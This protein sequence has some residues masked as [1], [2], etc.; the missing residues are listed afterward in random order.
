MN[1]A[2]LGAAAIPSLIGILSQNISLESIP[3]CLIVFYLI[4]FGCFCFPS[5]EAKPLPKKPN[6]SP[7]LCNFRHDFT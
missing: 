5:V 6:E 4:L 7:F 1:C 3:A 2:S